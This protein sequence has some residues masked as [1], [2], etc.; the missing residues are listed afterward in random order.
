[1]ISRCKSWLFEHWQQVIVVCFLVLVILK[2]PLMFAGLF[3]G[4]LYST[5]FYLSS[6]DQLSAFAIFMILLQWPKI[7]RS[8]PMIKPMFLAFILVFFSIVI[9]QF[10]LWPNQTSRE[11]LSSVF[12][13]SIPLAVMCYADQ[14]QKLLLPFFSFL[15]L[16]CM[17]HII[18]QLAKGMPCVGIAG[19]QNWNGAFLIADTPFFLYGL[20]K[21]LK[22]KSLATKTIYIILAVPF[23]FALFALIKAESRGANLALIIAVLLFLGLELNFSDDKK[24]QKYGKLFIKALTGIVCLSV[25]VVPLVYGDKMAEIIF[26]DV[27]IPLWKGAVDMFADNPTLGVGSSGYEGAYAYYMPIEK[28]LRSHYFAGRSTHPHNQFLFFA[29]AFGLLGFLSLAYL[30]LSPLILYFSKYRKASVFSKIVFYTYLMILIHAMLDLVAVRWPTMQFLLI[31]QGILLHKTMF[32]TKYNKAS[33]QTDESKTNCR[34][35]VFIRYLAWITSVVF[36]FISLKLIFVNLETTYF[37][38]NAIIAGDK[39]LLPLAVEKTQL[40]IKIGNRAIDVH[41]AAMQSIYWLNDYK[42]AYQFFQALEKH[43]AKLVVHSNSRTA[44]C[45]IEMNRKSEALKYYDKEIQVFPLSSIALYNKFLLQKDMGR[46]N[47]AEKTLMQLDQLMRF[48]GLKM[49][50]MKRILANPEFDN[51]FHELKEKKSIP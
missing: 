16:F 14:F 21:F 43:P 24:K 39:K 33:L 10:Q 35:P 46:E 23:V 44:Q 34:N 13:I 22:K 50:D 45:L 8:I 51:R 25:V 30:W 17:I 19:N 41:R 7:N 27:R 1:M 48:K 31:L 6:S 29:G 40:S 18:W 11:F 12:W 3:P 49:E 37:S 20:F 36:L 32:K 38:R 2:Y 4:G 26:R 47:A 5:S 28:F 9:F 15:W 42:L